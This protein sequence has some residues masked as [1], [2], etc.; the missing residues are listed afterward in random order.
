MMTDDKDV[1]TLPG[2]ELDQV[3]GGGV[4]GT[5]SGGWGVDGPVVS[6]MQ[7]LSNIQNLSG[8]DGQKTRIGTSTD[9][10]SSAASGSSNV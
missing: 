3:Q 4:F 5:P 2:E 1:K 9:G 6:G 10:F 8:T 7:S